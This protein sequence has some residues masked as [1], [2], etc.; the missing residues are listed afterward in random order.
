M[1]FW[2]GLQACDVISVGGSEIFDEVWQGGVN[3]TPKLRDVICNG[4]SIIITWKPETL[5]FTSFWLPPFS[6]DMT[7]H[8]TQCW[9]DSSVAERSQY[10]D[11]QII[12]AYFCFV[13]AF[14][15][16]LRS[17]ETNPVQNNF[18]LF[19]LSLFWIYFALFCFSC[20][21]RLIGYFRCVVINGSKLYYA[22]TNWHYHLRKRYCKQTWGLIKSNITRRRKGGRGPEQGELSKIL[23]FPSIFTWIA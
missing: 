16:H 7:S 21:S 23:G 19:I 15:S 6:Y 9:R 8:M 1:P 10:F 12:H 5:R 3:F 17:A 13:S 2:G 18:V 20:M 14:V 22:V 11:W 4:V